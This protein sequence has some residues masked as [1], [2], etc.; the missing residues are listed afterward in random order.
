MKTP[1]FFTASA[2]LFT[3]GNEDINGH[4]PM[5][6]SPITGVSPRGVNV[7]SG[8][9]A[10]LYE[11]EKGKSYVVKATELEPE[12]KGWQEGAS[13]KD[14][15]LI[16][17]FNY[18]KVAEIPIETVIAEALRPVKAGEKKLTVII[19]KPEQGWIKAE[20]STPVPTGGQVPTEEF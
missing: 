4:L 18:E 14:G 2:K 16:R 7:I 12:D 1:T 3:N 11:I 15:N 19:N 13:D 6:L 17:Q 5:I 10:E 20:V 9:S 8:T